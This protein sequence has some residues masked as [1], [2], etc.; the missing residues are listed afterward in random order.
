MIDLLLRALR[1]LLPRSSGG[2][3]LILKDYQERIATLERQVRGLYARGGRC[4]EH[5]KEKS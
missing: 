3:S 5:C 1:H 2:S 4:C